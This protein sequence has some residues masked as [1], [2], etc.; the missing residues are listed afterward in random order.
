MYLISGMHR[1]GTSLIAQ[2]FHR[3]G[4]DLGNPETLYGPDHWN[5]DG[6]FEQQAI[7]AVNI[8]LI[9]GPWGKLAYFHLPSTQTILRRSQRFRAQIVS[10]AAEYNDRIVKE[11]RFCLTLPAWLQHGT[12]VPA[13]LICLRHPAAVAQSLKRRN[14]IGQQLVYG[15]W[16]THVQRLLQAAAKIPTWII[17]YENILDRERFAVEFG[18][19]ARFFGIH[20]NESQLKQ[21]YHD[22]V[23]PGYNHHR[24]NRDDLPAAVNDLWQNLLTRHAEQQDGTARST[25]PG[26]THHQT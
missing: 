4:A 24:D 1:S 23:K 17:R 26:T 9:H 19:A 10:V 22:S 13:I 18:L 7:L 6:Y 20:L 3:A 14:W 16:Q 8:P 21:L 12:Q 11:T 2:L 5:P 15:L 25:I